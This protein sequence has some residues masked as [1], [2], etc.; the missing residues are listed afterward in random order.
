MNVRIIFLRIAALLFL[1]AP[2][3]AMD[4]T[5]TSDTLPGGKVISVDEAKS[6][7][8]KNTFFD[9]RT[10]MSYGKGHLPGARALPYKQ[11]SDKTPGFDASKDKFD[12]S[13][14][15]SDKSAAIVF[16]SDG[17]AGWKSYKAAVLAIRAGYSNV[18][19]FRGGTSEWE[20]NGH[21]LEK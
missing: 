1:A 4:K 16:Y 9:M 17:P 10:A 8:G 20:A 5:L 13:E 7:I 11:V 21:A 12:L 3:F 19:W 2:V 14:L 18:M 15:P 6:L